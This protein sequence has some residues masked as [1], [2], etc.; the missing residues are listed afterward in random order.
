MTRLR[1][2]HHSTFS[3]FTIIL[4]RGLLSHHLSRKTHYWSRLSSA[5]IKTSYSKNFQQSK[6]Q[7]FY[8][9]WSSHG[10]SDSNVSLLVL[11][12]CKLDVRYQVSFWK[13]VLVLANYTYPLSETPLLLESP[14]KDKNQ[15]VLK[16]RRLKKSKPRKRNVEWRSLQTNPI[17]E[18]KMIKKVAWLEKPSSPVAS[19]LE[20]RRLRSLVLNECWCMWL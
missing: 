9:P 12:N 14:N 13:K 5:G 15:F 16:L 4:R 19:E 3:F 7:V 20:S 11:K 18:L 8:Y 2:H 1:L 10:F 17:S 6:C